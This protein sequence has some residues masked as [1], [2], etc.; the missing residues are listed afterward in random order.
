MRAKEYLI[1]AS[2]QMPVAKGIQETMSGKEMLELTVLDHK[3]ET[4]ATHEIL[5]LIGA[6]RGDLPIQCQLLERKGDQIVLKKLMVMNPELRRNLRIPVQFHSFVY[7]LSGIWKG[8]KSVR[9]IDLSCGGIAFY[10]DRGMEIGETAEV[11]IPH[12]KNPLI[13]RI[14]I[15]RKQ[16]LKSERTYYAAKF[17]ELLPDEEQWICNKVFSI[18]LQNRTKATQT[19]EMEA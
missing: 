15:L 10:T 12:A 7:P 8:R 9:S 1:L 14:K 18:E 5:Y 11:V 17:I 4:V 6:E 19:E 2:D 13:V 3:T 16:E